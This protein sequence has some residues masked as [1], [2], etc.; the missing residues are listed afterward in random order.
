MKRNRSILH[1]QSRNHIASLQLSGLHTIQAS[2][3]TYYALVFRKV[4]HRDNA[5]GG[6]GKYRFI[7]QEVL[8]CGDPAAKPNITWS[9]AA[10]PMANSTKVCQA[11]EEHLRE[12]FPGFS[13]SFEVH[14]KKDLGYRT[15]VG[16]PI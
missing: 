15:G 1:T 16:R 10:G 5:I 14:V 11:V 4:S 2:A 9:I 6:I 13:T 12:H 7:V 8:A 3:D